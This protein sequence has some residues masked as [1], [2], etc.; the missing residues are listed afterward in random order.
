M[1]EAFK[2][3][4][5]WPDLQLQAGEVALWYIL[6]Q[7]DFSVEQALSTLSP[8]EQK[9]AAH[10]KAKGKQREYILARWFVRHILGL[11][12]QIPP[13]KV[14]IQW[15]PGE[16]PWLKGHGSWQFSLSHSKGMIVCLISSSLPVGVDVEFLGRKVRPLSYDHAFTPHEL[17]E[18][19]ELPEPQAKSRF[20]LRWTLKEA[21][22]K[23]VNSPIYI[24]FNGFEIRFEPLEVSGK[25]AEWPDRDRTFQWFRPEPN[26]LIAAD[27]EHAAPAEIAW[28][29]HTFA[30]RP[31]NTPH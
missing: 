15:T 9:R 18:H 6:D 21:L 23:A 25:V 29:F 3:H 27:V 4:V 31:L 2:R 1:E 19:K 10:F 11:Y 12:L 14:D 20:F 28:Q 5:D 7:P 13:Q 22:W 30:F 24:P 26:Y 8:S 16:K 17:R